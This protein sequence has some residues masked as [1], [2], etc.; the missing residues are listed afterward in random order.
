MGEPVHHQRELVAKSGGQVKISIRGKGST[1]KMDSIPG[2]PDEPLHVLLEGTQECVDKA[3]MLV[4]ELLE[5]SEA[6]EENLSKTKNFKY[7]L[8]VFYF[9]S[10]LA[11]EGQTTRTLSHFYLQVDTCCWT[12]KDEYSQTAQTLDARG[13]CNSLGCCKAI[14]RCWQET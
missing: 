13:R 2:M 10:L 6:A 14:P 7:Y 12:E 5:N 8:G 1:Q 9:T 3:E 4:R 11:A